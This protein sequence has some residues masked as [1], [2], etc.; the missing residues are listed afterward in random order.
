MGGIRTQ[1]KRDGDMAWEPDQG[2]DAR[3]DIR[4][5]MKRSVLVRCLHQRGH[6]NAA[7][8]AT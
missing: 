4:S 6:T 8:N 2:Q 3:E 7:R 5:S 1:N